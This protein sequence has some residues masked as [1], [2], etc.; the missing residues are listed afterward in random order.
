MLACFASSSPGKTVSS[1]SS[2]TI[3]A[4][5][6]VAAEALERAAWPAV[7]TSKAI[8][9]RIVALENE[10]DE[11]TREV[12]LAVRRQLHHPF[13][14]GEHQGSHPVDGRCDRHDAT[15]R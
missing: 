2:P 4:P 14:R 11:I 8:A 13:D 6:W 10:A 15:R 5:S 12:L 3:R 1:T 9:N 7:L